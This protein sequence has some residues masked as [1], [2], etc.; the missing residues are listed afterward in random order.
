MKSIA[1]FPEIPANKLKEMDSFNAEMTNKLDKTQEV[2]MVLNEVISKLKQEL[3]TKIEETKNLKTTI[4]EKERLIEK[5]KN[6]QIAL[7]KLKEEFSTKVIETKH[8]K[9]A[10][11]E[12]DRQV[13][14]LKKEAEKL[15]A[16]QKSDQALFLGQMSKSDAELDNARQAI[17]EFKRGFATQ[18]AAWTQEKTQLHEMIT[19]QRR[20][21]T[22]LTTKLGALGNK[23]SMTEDA[24]KQVLLKSLEAN[25]KYQDLSTKLNQTQNELEEKSVLYSKT[26]EG[27]RKEY[28]DKAKQLIGDNTRRIVALM[29]Q[30]ES[31]R[32]ELKKKDILLSEKQVKEQA[33][34]NDFVSKFKGIADNPEMS[35]APLTIPSLPAISPSQSASHE[36]IAIPEPEPFIDVFKDITAEMEEEEIE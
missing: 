8:L 30:V 4:A 36:D 29:A 2:V 17:A 12:R 9:I 28:A 16:K 34:V 27:M 25:K 22:L 24:N 14:D 19:A 23:L 20:E 35:S 33:L 18:E 1:D 32:N 10:T 21:I 13:L 5:Q 7:S 15:I 31:L 11:A 3:N 26:V 6:D